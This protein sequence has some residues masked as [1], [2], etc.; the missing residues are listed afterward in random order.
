M[1]ELR[2]LRYL[3]AVADE[4]H[5]TRAAERLGI[6]QPPL[7]RQIRLLEEE[8][9]VTLFERLPRGVRATEAG[10]VV[11]EEARD[12]IARAE[13]IKETA[14]R[15][16]RGEQGRLAVGYT[17]S[18]AFHPFVTQQIRA[19]R[20][21]RPGVILAL[22]EDGT[23]ELVSG[24]KEERLDAAF[25]RSASPDIAGLSLEPLLEEKMVVAVPVGHRLAGEGKVT[26]ADLAGE[27]FIFYRRPTGPG[28]Y[29][30]IMA[31][32]LAAGF[33][34]TVGQEAP[35]MASTLSLVASGLGVAIT[36]ASMQ[37]MNVEGVQFVRLRGT[38]GLVAPLLLA[39]RK[40]D[41]STLVD[42]FRREVTA[43]AR[44]LSEA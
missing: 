43:A 32:C 16:A 8:L 36:P 33:S 42:R 10:R 22:A 7:T 5:I 20:D 29:D 6:Q 21:A 28:L 41:R 38:K 3:V 18:A 30:A 24:L 37:R 17:S 14:Q 9:G 39:T 23:P 44:A 35:R 12:V 19:F 4:G 27:T 15:A 34:P 26:L 2:R 13:R 40:R 31:A 11:V 1:I 25:L